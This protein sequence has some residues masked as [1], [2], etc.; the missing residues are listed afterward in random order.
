M[1]KN[2]G[3]QKQPADNVTALPGTI[4][5]LKQ[6]NSQ[7]RAACENMHKRIMELQNGWAIQRAHF[8][9]EVVKTNGFSVEA[10]RKAIEELEG[11]L[12]PA[13]KEAE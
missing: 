2:N 4:E 5:A 9:F 6:E 12:F 7:L 3:R 11:F 1:E 13:E 8:L 10:K